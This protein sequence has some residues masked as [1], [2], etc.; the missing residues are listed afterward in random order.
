MDIYKGIGVSQGVAIYK[1][2]VIDAEDYRIPKRIV[3]KK[4]GY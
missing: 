4:R 1:A 2:V 3:P